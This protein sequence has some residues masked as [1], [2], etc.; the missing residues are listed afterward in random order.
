MIAIR[1]SFHPEDVDRVVSA[2]RAAVE[3]CGSYR[4]EFRIRRPSGEIRWIDVA[5][6]VNANGTN[7][8]IYDC[9]GTVAQI[10]HMPPPP[11]VI[12]SQGTFQIIPQQRVDL[13]N[14]V[15]GNAGA[16]IS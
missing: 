5:G 1:D 10:W 9:N 2:V 14:G 11:P 4:I 16:D 6:A 13:E 12:L 7:V 15:V 8:Q 3:S